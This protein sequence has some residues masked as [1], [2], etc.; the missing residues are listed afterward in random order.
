MGPSSR[1]VCRRSM[2]R[3]SIAASEQQ[4]LNALRSVRDPDLHQD[5]VALDFVKDLRISGGS[6][7]FTIELTTPAC[8]VK[9][10]MKAQAETAVRAVPGVEQVTVTMTAKVTAS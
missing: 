7:A 8:P 4:V 3:E 5:I 9:E 10:Q 6:V 2:P 1:L